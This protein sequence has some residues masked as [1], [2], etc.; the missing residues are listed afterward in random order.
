MALVD[1]GTGLSPAESEKA[2]KVI[3]LEHCQQ[4]FCFSLTIKKAG[5]IQAENKNQGCEE[6]FMSKQFSQTDVNG[7]YVLNKFRKVEDRAKGQGLT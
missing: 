7:N 5:G 3:F 2:R 6:T 1:R 4:Q